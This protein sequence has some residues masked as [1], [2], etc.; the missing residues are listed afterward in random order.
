MTFDV[1][2]NSPCVS[3]GG[4]QGYMLGE[5]SSLSEVTQSFFIMIIII[6]LFMCQR[7]W[8]KSDY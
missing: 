2:L 8:H 5:S 6:S 1:I 7:I 3:Q 4:I